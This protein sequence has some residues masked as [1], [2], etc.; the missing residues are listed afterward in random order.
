MFNSAFTQE[1]QATFK[2][3]DTDGNG[4]VTAKEL[5]AKLEQMCGRPLQMTTVELFM[6]QY[7]IDGDKM[8]SEAELAEFLRKNKE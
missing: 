8:W 7:D 1:V 2:E 6:K 3:L 4:T 5:K